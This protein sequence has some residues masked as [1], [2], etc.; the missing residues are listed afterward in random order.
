[1]L[2]NKLSD[3]AFPYPALMDV[4][5]QLLKYVV[6]TNSIYWYKC[7]EMGILSHGGLRGYIIELVHFK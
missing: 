4:G 1:M 6:L 5:R 2:Q 3:V 7:L